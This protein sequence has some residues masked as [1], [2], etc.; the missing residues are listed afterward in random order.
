[1]GIKY[2]TK[3]FAVASLVAIGGLLLSHSDSAFADNTISLTVSSSSVILDLVPTSTAGTF[4]KSPALDIS[5]S[6]TGDGGYILGIHSATSGA[7]ATKLIH[8]SDNTKS[9]TSISSAL[10]ESD[11]ASAS[12][13]Q[14][15]NQWG[16]LPSKYNSSDNTSFLPSPTE[17]GDILDQ[18]TGTNDS[19][20]Y[21][22]AIGA[23]ANNET[24][25]G[26]YAGTYVI[27][28]IANHSC[29]PLATTIVEAL[30]MQDISGNNPNADAVINSMEEGRQYQLK[31]NRDWKTYYVAKMKDGRVWM[32]QNL[33]LDLETMPTN[34]AALTHDNTDLGWTSLNTNATWTPST[35]TVTTAADY[36]AD[37]LASGKTLIKAGDE[38]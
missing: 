21:T 8:T 6:L 34:V 1:M 24:A 16:Y 26:S 4:T 17:T 14:Y 3:L 5:V 37:A 33:D 2:K 15:N 23:R 31:D 13:T 38:K 22:I 20:N 10:S 36:E 25:V 27:T 32:T 12:N 19:G 11:F 18:T 7:D 29:N 9:F 28:A 35:A 30:C